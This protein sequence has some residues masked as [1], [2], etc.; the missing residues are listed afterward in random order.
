MHRVATVWEVGFT[1]LAFLFLAGALVLAITWR[2]KS[3]SGT[4][5]RTVAILVLVLLALWLLWIGLVI[6]PE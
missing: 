6:E 1:G 4:F 5:V 3:S 2:P